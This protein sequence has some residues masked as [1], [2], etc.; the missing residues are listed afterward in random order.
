MDLLVREARDGAL[1]VAVL[2]DLTMAARYCDRLLLIDQG[3]LIADGSPAE[4]L[5]VE[6]MAQVYGIAAMVAL[7]GPTPMIVPLA[8]A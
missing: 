6:R 8:R 4:V 5:T 7:D 1:V 2:H 3:A